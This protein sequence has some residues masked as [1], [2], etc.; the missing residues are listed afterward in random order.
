MT[1]ASPELLDLISWQLL[2]AFDTQDVVAQ[3]RVQD[4]GEM[5]QSSS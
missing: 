5:I 2:R 4:T 3:T 1:F